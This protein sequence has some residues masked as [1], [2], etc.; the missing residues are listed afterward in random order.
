[1]LTDSLIDDELI[2]LTGEDSQEDEDAQEE[3][4]E[5]KRDNLTELVGILKKQTARRS[6]EE[7]ER[8]PTAQDA[9]I[10]ILKKQMGQYG[11]VCR[12]VGEQLAAMGEN[13]R[14]S[15]LSSARTQT[16]WLDSEKMEEVLSQSGFELADLKRKKTTIYLSLPAMR[17][18]THRDGCA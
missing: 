1:M 14:G 16:Q 6:H 9:L 10:S 2:S 13:E 4:I 12:G 18:P 17:L 3:D 7:H 5:E 8:K 15:V 11:H